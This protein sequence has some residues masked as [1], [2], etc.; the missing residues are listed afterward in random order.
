MGE[1]REQKEHGQGEKRYPKI[2]FFSLT[3]PISFLILLPA[4]RKYL[5]NK[6]KTGTIRMHRFTNIT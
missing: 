5:T 1:Y 6:I 4:N 3:V 2:L